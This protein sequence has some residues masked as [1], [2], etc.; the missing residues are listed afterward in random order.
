LASKT[1]VSV[2]IQDDE[3]TIHRKK[4]DSNGYVTKVNLVAVEKADELTVSSG[5]QIFS[6]NLYSK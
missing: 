4:I 2:Y 6:F 5:D 3:I 1:V